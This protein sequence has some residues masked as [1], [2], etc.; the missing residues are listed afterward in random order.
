MKAAYL[1]AH[2]RPEDVCICSEVDDVG[3]PAAGEAV[4]E[5]RAAAI[6]PADLLIM[7]GRYPG[8][9]ELPAPMGIEGAGIVVA[10]GDGVEGLQPGDHVI[11]MDRANWAE[12]IRVAADRLVRVPGELPFRDAAQLKA[13]PPSA[14]FMLNDYVDFEPGDW[15]VQNAANSAVGRHVIRLAR[16]RGI[17]TAN[18]VRRDE[19]VGPLGELGANVVA[20]DGDDLARRIRA[21]AGADARI[22]L[23]LDAVGG[24]ACRRL[25]ETVSDGATLANYGFLSG[26]PCMVDPAH[27]ILRGLTLKGF[28]LVPFMRDAGREQRDALY[29]EM[30]RHFIDGTLVAPVEAVYSLDEIGAALAHAGRGSRDGK[31]IVAPSGAVD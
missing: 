10:V 26:E 23:G 17:R 13:N 29:A 6:N 5:I 31:V 18:V 22:R 30:A 25:A 16:K 27:L 2:G 8:P 14:H 24:A 20:V 4:V 21:A 9:A 12:R 28:W 19:L 11:S 7:A 15:L 1:T 3:E